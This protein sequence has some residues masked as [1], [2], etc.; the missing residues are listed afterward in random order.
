MSGSCVGSTEGNSPQ[1][2][3]LLLLRCSRAFASLQAQPG[4]VSED[5]CHQIIPEY[6]MSTLIGPS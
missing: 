5:R 6:V 2:P 3:L 1:E 4:R